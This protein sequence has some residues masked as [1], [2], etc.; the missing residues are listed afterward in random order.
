MLTNE[1]N[2]VLTKTGPGTPMGDMFRTYW[3]PALLGE[4]LPENDC[5]PVRVKL[6]SESLVAFRDSEGRYG[7][8]R[9]VLRASRS[10][11]VV[12]PQ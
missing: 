11:A 7:L 6:L 9:R 8:V 5:A 1:Q 12:R 2:A 4:E 3:M 10:V